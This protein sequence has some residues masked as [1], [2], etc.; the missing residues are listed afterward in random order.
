MK[1]NKIQ[2]IQ[3]DYCEMIVLGWYR[4]TLQ[5]DQV[6]IVSI[7][8]AEDPLI[9]C[10]HCIEYLCFKQVSAY[11]ISSMVDTKCLQASKGPVQDWH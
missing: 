10:M 11:S 9:R 1:M 5:M 3:T 2:Y 8:D 4:P 6:E 7:D